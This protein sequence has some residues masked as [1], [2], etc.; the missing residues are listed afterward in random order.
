[1]TQEVL[2]TRIWLHRQ[3][4]EPT[5]EMVHPKQSRNGNCERCGY[6]GP[7]WLVEVAES[8]DTTY[9]EIDGVPVFCGKIPKESAFMCTGEI[10]EEIVSE[11]ESM[12][13]REEE[14]VTVQTTDYET[15]TIAQLK[16]KLRE[17]EKR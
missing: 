1:M 16:A 2:T 12:P 17:L 13:Q 9:T 7:L 3:C 11:L 6:E 5:D 4:I 15:M 10:A 8:I 14:K